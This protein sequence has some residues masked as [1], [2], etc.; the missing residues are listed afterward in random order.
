MSLSKNESNHINLLDD[1][2]DSDSIPPSSGLTYKTPAATR[3]IPTSTTIT[4][5]MPPRSS[6]LISNNAAPAPTKSLAAKRPA[7]AT[8][9]NATKKKAKKTSPKMYALIWI[10]THGKGQQRAWRQKDLKIVGVYASKAL[11]EAAKE[12][13]M[14]QHECCGHGDILVGGSWDD[15]I[16]LVIRE[17]P[18][19]LEEE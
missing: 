10:C 2:D 11:A 17:A 8:K 5:S 16:D 14:S 9:N 19:F 7:V 1:D 12:H 6:L 18:L 3:T 4:P 13:V 15:E